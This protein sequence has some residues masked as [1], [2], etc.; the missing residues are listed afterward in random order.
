[1]KREHKKKNVFLHVG[2]SKTGSS[3]IQSFLALNTSLLL[4]YGFDY[5]AQRAMK[6]A[7]EGKTTSG[8]L[9]T[10]TPSSWL[11]AVRTATESSACSNILFSHERLFQLILEE[12]EHL[13]AALKKYHTVII[14]Y[15]RNPLDH[16]LSAYGQAVKRHGETR[17]LEEWADSYR[18]PTKVLDFL[19]VC[20]DLD[21]S[22]VV[23]NYSRI[24]C[25]EENFAKA[26]LGQKSEEF[27]ENSERLQHQVNRSMT[28]AEYELLRQLNRHLD[29]SSTAA[30]SNVLADSLPQISSEREYMTESLLN[31]T[32]NRLRGVINEINLFLDCDNKLELT[33]SIEPAEPSVLYSFSEEQIAVIASSVSSLVEGERKNIL[34]KRVR[35]LLPESWVKYIRGWALRLP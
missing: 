13:S 27:F 18:H 28:R 25:I 16:L 21:A 14:L 1:M 6:I 29:S 12:P 22:L 33:D 9:V 15:V 24:S 20:K 30:I 3:A 8:N 10:S 17:K 35:E 11:P 23:Q 4:K 5:P 32:C 7:R 2:H 31:R 19:H 26:V 34:R